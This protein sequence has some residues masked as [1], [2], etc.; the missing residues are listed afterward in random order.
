MR[1]ERNAGKPANPTERRF[2]SDIPLGGRVHGQMGRLLLSHG[3]PK[4]SL[5]ELQIASQFAM[6]CRDTLMA[7]SCIDFMS[8]AF[9]TPPFL[10]NAV[11]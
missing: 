10:Q 3:A 2:Y 1:D 8:S 4:N 5:D 6:K 7:L 11:R 9:H